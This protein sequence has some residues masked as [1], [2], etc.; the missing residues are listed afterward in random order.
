MSRPGSD[1]ETT[2]VCG[3]VEPWIPFE[4][5][6]GRVLIRYHRIDPVEGQIVAAVRLAAEAGSAPLYHTGPVIA[7]TISGAW[8]YREEDWVSKAGDTVYEAAGSMHTAESI[9][10]EETVVFLVVTGEFL[11][12]DDEGSL[13]WQESW[14]TSMERHA[15]YC[16]A[17]GLT[18]MRFSTQ[19]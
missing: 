10:D 1:A 18:P 3:R 9:G 19:Y 4:P 8:R 17:K 13:I 11:F 14:R 7:H 16:M 12:F 5:L 2:Y 15:E 6:S